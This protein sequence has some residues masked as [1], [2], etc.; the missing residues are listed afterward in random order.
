MNN[1]QWL[2]KFYISNCNGD[3]EHSYG[4]KISTLDNPG[5]SINIDLNETDYSGKDFAWVTKEK[6]EENWIHYK[7]EN[8][9][10]N[11]RCGTLNLDESIGIFREWV[12]KNK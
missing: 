1:L 7:L 12:D 11:I 3:W 2:Q 4:I 6:S 5:W 8:D 10:F 9:I